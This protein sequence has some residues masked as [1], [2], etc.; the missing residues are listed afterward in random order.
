MQTVSLCMICKNEERYLPFVFESVKDLACEIIVNDTG[1]SDRTVEICEAYK[2]FVIQTGWTRD[3]SF[4]RNLST[5]NAIGDW[6][7]WLDGDEVFSRE[8]ILKIK[9]FLS[10]A[11]S[12]KYDFLAMPRWNFWHDTTK[13]FGYPDTQYKIYRNNIGLKWFGKIHEYVFNKNSA[14]H[15]KRVKYSDVH[16][17]HYAYMKTEDEVAGKMA[18]Y[19]KIENPHMDDKEIRKCSREHSFFMSSIKNEHVQPYFGAYPEIFS[20]LEIVPG[21]GIFKV[22]GEQIHKFKQL[23]ETKKVVEISDPNLIAENNMLHRKTNEMQ[24]E[25]NDLKNEVNLLMRKNNFEHVGTREIQQDITIENVPFTKPQ[26]PAIKVSVVIASNRQ[27]NLLKNCIYSIYPKVHEPFEIIV[28]KNCGDENLKMLNICEELEKTFSNLHVIDLKENLGFA[29]GYNAGIRETQGEYVLVLNDDTEFLTEDVFKNCIDFLN[30]KNRAAIISCRSNNMAG[31]HQNIPNLM[32][33]SLDECKGMYTQ[34]I[35]NDAIESSWVTGCFMFTTRKIIECLHGQGHGLF[36]DEQFLVGEYED[37]DLIW[38]IQHKIK[39]F[40][41]D[42]VDQLLG[43]K[44]YVAKNVIVFH[45]GSM[46]LN[47]IPNR[48]R[49]NEENKERLKRKWPDIFK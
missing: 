20:E 19:I 44:I 35:E 15:Q 13:V 41:E 47:E 34:F 32:S 6:I 29:K 16:L 39:C 45:H 48:N 12:N 28:V 10:S 1:S 33:R 14:A 42:G 27:P 4:H 11:E 36:F 3:F 26:N 25:I 37:T 24:S 40:K 23:D 18:N 21:N 49:I 2:A 46:T 5:V 30:T 38:R 31:E 17:H 43:G 9:A 7:L 22:T 8:N